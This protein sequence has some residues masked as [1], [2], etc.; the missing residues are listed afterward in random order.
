MSTNA[1][2]SWRN[3]LGPAVVSLSGMFASSLLAQAAGA[4]ALC[5]SM[6]PP[7]PPGP[8]VTRQTYRL[9]KLQ[10]GRGNYASCERR[11][12]TSLTSFVYLKPYVT[13]VIVTVP[14]AVSDG[15]SVVA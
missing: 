5:L 13:G 15:R 11:S 6:L 4:G 1:F 3:F 9:T 8:I 12:S 7:P 14:T 2:H 10:Q